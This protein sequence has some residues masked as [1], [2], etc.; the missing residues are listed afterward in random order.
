MDGRAQ[1]MSDITGNTDTHSDSYRDREF[2][3]VETYNNEIMHTHTP[4][5]TDNKFA[6]DEDAQNKM[7][8][9]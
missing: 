5:P 6:K 2:K 3:A 1:F 8:M 7:K 9:T 4:T